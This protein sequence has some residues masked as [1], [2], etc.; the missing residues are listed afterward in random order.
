M[1]EVV[2]DGSVT[3]NRVVVVR[4]VEKSLAQA[5]QGAVQRKVDG[6]GAKREELLEHGR[7]DGLLD[8][9]RFARTGTTRDPDDPP[10][11]AEEYFTERVGDVE[12]FTVAS[13]DVEGVVRGERRDEGLVH[14]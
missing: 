11:R 13:N 2:E 4:V 12:D 8:H 10:L 3:D 1:S 5:P 9:G 7:P 14:A 6:V